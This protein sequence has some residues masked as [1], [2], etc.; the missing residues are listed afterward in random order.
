[1]IPFLKE[2]RTLD[3]RFNEGLLEETWFH[4]EITCDEAEARLALN[5]VYLRMMEKKVRI[6]YFALSVSLSV[7]AFHWEL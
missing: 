6:L 1:M 3:G 4:G 2:G 5:I 7:S